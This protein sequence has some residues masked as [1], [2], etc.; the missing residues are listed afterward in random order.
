MVHRSVMRALMLLDF[1]QQEGESHGRPVVFLFPSS[2]AAYGLPSLAAKAAVDRVKE[3]HHNTPTTMYGCN[4]LYGELLG[5]Y[6]S[7]Y[8][9]QLA[10]DPIRT[11]I[12][13]R[14]IRFPGLI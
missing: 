7:S 11:R 12:D 4:K 10:A 5:A 3:E 1:A 9:K 2:I 14:G 6:Y 13:F 8:Y